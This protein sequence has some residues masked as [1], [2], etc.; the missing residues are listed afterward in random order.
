MSETFERDELPTDKLV[1]EP[2]PAKG[3]D[4]ESFFETL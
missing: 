2:T 3:K 1:D 4:A